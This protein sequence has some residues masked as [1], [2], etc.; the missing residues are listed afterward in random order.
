[1][2]WRCI[3]DSSTG[4][5]RSVGTVWTEPPRPGTDFRESVDR[6]DQGPNMWDEATRDWVPRPPKIRLDRMDD[7]EGHPTFLQFQEVFDTL[8]TQ[9]KVKVRNAIR[10]ML[11]TEQF[12]KV[13]ESLEIG[14]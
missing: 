14:K 2:A 12:R 7:L 8:I 3:F 1:M 6:P 13:N 5:L 9:Q 10:K 11:G 4:R